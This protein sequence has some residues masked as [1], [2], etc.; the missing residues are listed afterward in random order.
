MN[1]EVEKAVTIVLS[2]NL[3]VLEMLW[4]YILYLEQRVE[5]LERKEVKQ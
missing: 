4:K 2:H 3:K 5:E 1:S